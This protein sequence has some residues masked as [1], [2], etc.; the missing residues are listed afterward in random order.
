MCLQQPFH[1]P[2]HKLEEQGAPADLEESRQLGHDQQRCQTAATT[3]PLLYS[4]GFYPMRNP[5]SPP[6]T[7]PAISRPAPPATWGCRGSEE[8]ATGTG[9]G[10]GGAGRPGLRAQGRWRWRSRGVLLL[11]AAAA[12]NPRSG[13]RRRGRGRAG[14]QA[15]RQGVRARALHLAP[16]SGLRVART[17]GP[18][19]RHGESGGGGVRGVCRGALREGIAVR[20]PRGGSER[21]SAAGVG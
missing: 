21:V 13:R 10:R 15:G 20:A 7:S 4:M 16:S 19:R 17:T 12:P 18:R 14:R 2:T 8:P 11:A 6:P 9:A 5:P 3:L 1:I